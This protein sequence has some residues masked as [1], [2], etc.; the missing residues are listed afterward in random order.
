MKTYICK[1]AGYQEDCP[2]EAESP[3][4]AAAQF[5]KDSIEEN[6]VQDALSPDNVIV[7]DEN[8]VERNYLCRVGISVVDVTI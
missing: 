1:F 5:Y 4:D 8:G 7:T 2:V 3:E 6:F